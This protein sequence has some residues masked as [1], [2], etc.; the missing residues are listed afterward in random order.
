M[1]T[2]SVTGAPSSLQ[3]RL[4]DIATRDERIGLGACTGDSGA[5]VYESS[6]AWASELVD[7]AAR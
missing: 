3:V 6:G 1:A 4:F 2:L 7:R 5:P